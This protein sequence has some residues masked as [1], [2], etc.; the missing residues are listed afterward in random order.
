MSCVLLAGTTRAEPVRHI[1]NPEAKEPSNAPPS[2][3]PTT[4]LEPP[5]PCAPKVR[6]MLQ[7]ERPGSRVTL[8]NAPAPFGNLA[9]GTRAWLKQSSCVTRG[10]DHDRITHTSLAGQPDGG[11]FSFVEKPASARLGNHRTTVRYLFHHPDNLHA[12]VMRRSAYASFYLDIDLKSP[13]EQLY[14]DPFVSRGLFE[15][16]FAALHEL[17]KANGH[18]PQAFLRYSVV[19][20]ACGPVSVY[21][22][23]TAYKSSFRLIFDRL[24]LDVP[25]SVQVADHL[26]ISLRE[27]LGDQWFGVGWGDILDRRVYQPVIGTRM[28]YCDKVRWE[29]CTLCRLNPGVGIPRPSFAH[30]KRS[31]PD[32]GLAQIAKKTRKKRRQVLCPVSKCGYIWER[33]PL[34]PLALLDEFGHPMAGA[35][36]GA[37]AKRPNAVNPVLWTEFVDK[38]NIRWPGATGNSP[39]FAQGLPPF[40]I[41][42]CFS[43]TSHGALSHFLPAAPAA[44][45]PQRSTNVAVGPAAVTQSQDPGEYTQPTSVAARPAAKR[46]R[47]CHRPA[48]AS[49]TLVAPQW[50][51]VVLQEETP[52]SSE[53]L[54]GTVAPGEPL[55]AIDYTDFLAHQIQSATAET[56]SSTREH[57]T[58]GAAYAGRIAKVW[59]VDD[60]C[61]TVPEVAVLGKLAHQARCVQDWGAFALR[62]AEPYIGTDA[63]I[64]TQD[65]A[66]RHGVPILSV[67]LER[68]MTTICPIKSLR[69][70]STGKTVVAHKNGNQHGIRLTP[71]FLSFTCR[72]SGC[73]QYQ[74]AHGTRKF[75]LP[76]HLPLPLT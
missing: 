7:H 68:S 5:V 66:V 45:L 58:A 51:S 52:T 4:P 18:D 46:R 70:D 43:N 3:P 74:S 50:Q 26:E 76:W 10:M 14:L 42:A 40:A 32:P 54:S 53:N 17:L 72:S 20:S 22:K 67:C 35:T 29:K 73:L 27:K 57:D 63:G 31:N 24:V 30:K 48:P 33:R 55:D 9:M 16:I 62:V 23:P 37:D 1:R 25:T 15:T 28:I 56:R 39:T 71:G 2:T 12:L 75:R 61:F 44:A 11:N 6:H 64:K 47:L 59:G 38:T 8:V 69:Q 60:I 21:G 34:V 41:P 19:M 65:L 49:H 36:A 13:L